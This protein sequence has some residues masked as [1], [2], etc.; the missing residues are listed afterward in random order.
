[1]DFLLTEVY[2]AGD[3]SNI[4]SAE[5]NITELPTQ[6]NDENT[7]ENDD[8]IQGEFLSQLSKFIKIE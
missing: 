7:H 1:M 2:L 8:D 3:M 5:K 6:K 4:E